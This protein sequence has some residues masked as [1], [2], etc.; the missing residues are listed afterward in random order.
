MKISAIGIVVLGLFL[1]S[2]V[3]G[4]LKEIDQVKWT[5][6]E[7]A[8]GITWKHAH[9]DAL[10]GESQNINVLEI[11]TRK[12]DVTLVYD[13]EKNR[14]TS[15]MAREAKAL[16]AV[17]AGFFDMKNGGST[18][19]IKVDGAV[20]D[21][22]TLKWMRHPRYSGA[23]I[24]TTRGR[25]GIEERGDH[26]RYSINRKYDD[27]L[28]TGNLLMDDGTRVTLKDDTFV[29][30]RHPRTCLG[31]ISKHK[32]ILVTVD[33]RFEQAAGMSLHELTDLMISLRCKEAINLDGGGS[34]TM[35]LADEGVVNMPS[36]NKKFD[37]E[38]ERPVSNII[39]VR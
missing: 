19:Y 15:E 29:T 12:R 3:F 18:A 33:G 26:K 4:Q 39:V 13:K 22:D 37:H 35:W 30:T 9:I 14:P 24:I 11:D 20:P 21:G 28:V 5:T 10:H 34:T 7:V 1:Q 17:N 6:K 32:M 38:G 16:A 2:N 27:V 25:I 8:K 31:I 36:D 23:L